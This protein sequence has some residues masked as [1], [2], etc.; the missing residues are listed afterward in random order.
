VISLYTATLSLC[1]PIG[2]IIQGWLGDRIGLP[3]T[4]LVAAGGLV[5]A[6]AI[7]MLSG[8]GFL[9]GLNDPLPPGAGGGDPEPPVEVIPD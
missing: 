6:Y 9:P 3:R 7:I 1:F 8:R 5:V 4:T 2:S